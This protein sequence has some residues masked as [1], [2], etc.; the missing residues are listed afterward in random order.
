M[1]R[2]RLLRLGVGIDPRIARIVS[3]PRR[4]RPRSEIASGTNRPAKSKS[5]VDP[6][7]EKKKEKRKNIVGASSKYRVSRTRIGIEMVITFGKMAIPNCRE[8]KRGEKRKK[9]GDGRKIGIGAK[10]IYIYFERN[11]REG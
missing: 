5:G 4:F 11:E 2:L 10:Y 8:T 7:P 1:Q 6:W 3:T 9:G